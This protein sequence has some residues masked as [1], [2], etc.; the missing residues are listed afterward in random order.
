MHC[1]VPKIVSTFC[2]QDQHI[3]PSVCKLLQMMRWSLWSLWP[4]L[5]PLYSTGQNGH[6]GQYHEQPSK[7]VNKFFVVW[8]WYWPEGSHNVLRVKAIMA[9]LRSMPRPYY[10]GS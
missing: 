5:H 4:M 7:Y 3:L 10:Q 1:T 8:P 2:A 6:K 9:V